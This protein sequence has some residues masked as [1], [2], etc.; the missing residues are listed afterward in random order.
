MDEIHSYV[1]KYIAVITND[2]SE[3][4]ERIILVRIKQ[5]ISSWIQMTQRKL[6]VVF[7]KYSMKSSEVL[8]NG[9]Q[10]KNPEA[11]MSRGLSRFD[12]ALAIKHLSGCWVSK[13]KSF[14]EYI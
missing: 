2:K 6:V 13:K 3:F 12:P 10:E 5:S 11:K 9:M 4:S 14:L 8:Q 7:V 1:W